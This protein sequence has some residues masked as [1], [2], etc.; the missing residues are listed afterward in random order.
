MRARCRRRR[1]SRLT[2]RSLGR[3]LQS[4]ICDLRSLH[5]LEGR[6]AG[7][8]SLQLCRQLALPA[9]ARCREVLK[10]TR[11]ASA[12]CNLNGYNGAGAHRTSGFVSGRREDFGVGAASR[13]KQRQA[14]WKKIEATIKPDEMRTGNTVNGFPSSS[15]PLLSSCS[16]CAPD[17]LGR[18]KHWQ[19]GTDLRSHRTDTWPSRG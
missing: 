7:W 17:G 12:C 13:R 10:Q 14:T 4:L 2:L 16:I 9:L 15:A 1:N 19:S 8:G 5:L 18:D 6:Q 11:V 3:F